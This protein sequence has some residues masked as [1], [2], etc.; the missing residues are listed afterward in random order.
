MDFPWTFT[1]TG[2][3][4]PG[5]SLGEIAQTST[6]KHLYAKSDV[7]LERVSAAAEAPTEG[8]GSPPQP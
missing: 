1:V 2:Y 4:F 6:G 5:M 3:G 8:H 7:T